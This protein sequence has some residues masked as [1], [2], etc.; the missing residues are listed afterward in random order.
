LKVSEMKYCPYCHR[1]NLDRPQLCN[2][3]GRS[4][5]TRLCPRGHENPPD[6]QF[7]GTCGSADLTDTAGPKPFWL[8]SVRVGFGM[9]FLLMIIFAM[10]ALPRILNLLPLL[11]SFL[12]AITLLLIAY[13][14]GFSVLPAPMRKPFQT[15]NAMIKK[16]LVNALR[17]LWEKIKLLF[18]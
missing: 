3:C 5:Y 12:I 2:Y 7:C 15:F 10:R 1:W 14:L 13:R 17:W 16:G 18:S 11:A 9:V 8:R 4:W 6:A